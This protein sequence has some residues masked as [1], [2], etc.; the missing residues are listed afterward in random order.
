M[1]A[2]IQEL[3]SALDHANIVS[4][5]NQR[6]LEKYQDSIRQSQ[7]RLDDEQKARAIAREHLANM[8]RRAHSLQNNLEEMRT[9]LEQTDRARRSAEQELT[10][11]SENISD[12][13]NQNQSIA[14]NKRHLESEMDTMKQDL[15]DANTEARMVEDK[16]RM[17]MMDA[18]KLAGGPARAGAVDQPD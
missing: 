13:Q 14:T 9:L 3:E 10:E 18:A 1:E 12:L 6:N 16:A 7:L 17:A 4:N 5:E 11:A 8:D 15:D 2:D